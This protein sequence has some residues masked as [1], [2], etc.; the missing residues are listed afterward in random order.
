MSLGEIT[1]SVGQVNEVVVVTG[2]AVTL[3]TESAE[4]SNQIDAKQMQN[5]AVNGRSYLGLAYLTPGVVSNANFQVAGTAGLGAISANGARYNQNQLLLNG[6]SNV[7]TGNNGDQLAT[8]SL[9]SVQ[10]FRI[11]T[12]SYQ[13]EYGRSA[14]AQIIVQT[15]T[16]TREFHGS[17]YYFR[18]H[19]SL[20]ANTWFRN[21]IVT[22]QFID[23]R[24]QDVVGLPRQLYRFQYPGYTIGG[25]VFFPKL[26]KKENSRLFFFWSQEY[27]RQLQ[28]EA[29]R[30]ITVPTALERNGDF[31]QS[32]NN[33]GQPLGAIRDPLS[34]APFPEARIPASRIW[35]PGR[36]LLNLFPLPNQDQRIFLNYNYET[37]IST[38]RP[39]REDLLRIDFNATDNLRLWG[40]WVN[41]NNIFTSPYGSFVL[42]SNVGAFLI[43]D[44]RPGKSYAGGMAYTINPTMTAEVTVG[45]GRNDILIEPNAANADALTR[46]RTNVNLPLLYPEAVQRDFIPA[47]TFNGTRLSNSP[48]FGTGNA[49]FVNFNDTT[50]VNA[51]LTKVASKHV[52]KFGLYLQR[53]RKNQTS[54]ANANGNYN[55]GDNPQNPL[56]TNFGFANALL[57]VYNSFTQARTYANGQYRYYNVEGYVQDT[58]KITRRLTLDYGLRMAWIQP[59]HDASLIVSSFRPDRFRAED[60]SRLFEPHR[61]AAGQIIGGIDPVTGATTSAVNIGRLVPG[62]GN[63]LNG[64]VLPKKD[65]NKYL[66]Q[67]RGIHWGPRFGL[68]FD[69]LGN[70]RMVLRTGGGIFY[71]RFQGNR[72]FDLLTNPPTVLQPVL[73]FG[74]AQEINPAT[75]LLGPPGLVMADPTGVNPTTYNF[76][77]GIQTKLPFEYVLDVAY[78]G[79][80]ARH[81]QNNR[82]INAVPY[83]AFFRN[84]QAFNAD[85]LRPYR[86]FGNINIYEGT[87][88]SNFNSLQVTASRRFQSFQMDLNYTWGKA[89]G[90][91]TTDGEFTRI[92]SLQRFANY[93]YLDFHR[94]HNMNINFIYELPKF[95]KSKLLGLAVNNWQ[96]S[97]IYTYISGSPQG[98]GFSIPGFV[99]QNVT[100]SFTEG[101]RLRLVGDPTKGV[102][103]GLFDKLNPEAFLPPQIGSIGVE[104]SPRIVFL[105]PINNWNMSFQKSFTV[106]E[107]MNLQ[108]RADAFNFFNHTQF[109]DFNRTVNFPSLNA[110]QATNFTR[111]L[112]GFG[113]VNGVRDP[114]IMQLVAR[115]VF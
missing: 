83:G 6:I 106:R 2:E 92:D 113:A 84:P 99:N 93:S 76:N 103:R 42:G 107:G 94:K 66:M 56:D 75:A 29:P 102:S 13:A 73:N 60:A 90:T 48:V 62:S 74:F 88:T 61:N 86:G 53:S 71:D 33:Q 112:G 9:D 97:G 67:D 91:G 40:H 85:F 22:R 70:Q 43:D 23:G 108:L 79:N 81:L 63:L 41:N 110:T 27:Q 39:R 65:V 12:G 7:D 37:Q 80:L 5:L 89:L 36:A 17:A 72:T 96:I 11:L 25:P 16:G 10:E 111:T 82:N 105:P 34:G 4:R 115:F 20:N 1:L 44:G 35:A 49:P 26:L 14:G 38:R 52:F 3:K 19:D 8:I 15:K 100:G 30:R 28:P 59:Q 114:R 55:F 98:V 57:G 77:F 50:D 45:W 78:V 32:L 21:N 24:F 68:A 47:F 54:F 31:S 104:M 46:R 18:R 51:N 58:F 87:V 109:S 64:I 95:S 69:V 101:A